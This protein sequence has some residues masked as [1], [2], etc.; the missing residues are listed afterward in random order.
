VIDELFGDG[1]SESVPFVA[2]IGA[3][4]LL[5]KSIEE[6]RKK[7]GVGAHAGILDLQVYGVCAVPGAERDPAPRLC[8]LDRVAEQIVEHA[9]ECPA[10]GLH[11]EQGVRH[12][13]L[14]FDVLL[15]RPLREEFGR[16]VNF[17]A[18]VDR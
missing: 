15:P 4:R 9:L 14:E 13:G 2:P 1:H 5:L 10:I 7:I 11:P 17:L 6:M 18:H 12:F 8:K 16:F 3:F